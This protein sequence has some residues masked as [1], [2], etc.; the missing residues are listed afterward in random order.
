MLHDVIT[1]IYRGEYLIELE[2]DD[3][4]RGVVDFSHYRERG[5]VFDR[6]RDIEFFRDFSVN[7]EL[8]VLTWGNEIDLAP[9]ILYAKATGSGLPAWMEPDEQNAAEQ[10]RRGTAK[11]AKG[12]KKRNR[13]PVCQRSVV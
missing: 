2:F 6:F 12:V 11:Q 9:E 7:K 10:R 1:A 8:G 3:G 4:K 5:G 13:S